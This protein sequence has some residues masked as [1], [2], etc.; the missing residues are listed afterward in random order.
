[1]SLF[2]ESE[3]RESGV[4]VFSSQRPPW[5]RVKSEKK[6][7]GTNK[8][9]S[10]KIFFSVTTLKKKSAKVIDLDPVREF[11]CPFE[12]STRPRAFRPKPPQTIYGKKNLVEK[13]KSDAGGTRTKPFRLSV[14]K[15]APL[16]SYPNTMTLTS[17]VVGYCAL[18]VSW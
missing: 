6:K 11:D 8:F 18:T 15:Y 7:I 10:N 17:S 9:F 1:L 12:N 4:V 2:G 16:A 13:H 5:E 14:R 3:E